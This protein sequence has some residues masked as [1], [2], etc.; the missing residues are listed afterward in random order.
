MSKQYDTP[1]RIKVSD[2]GKE[3]RRRKLQIEVDAPADRFELVDVLAR[4]KA[5]ERVEKYLH[6]GVESLISRY[7]EDGFTVLREASRKRSIDIGTQQ[8]EGE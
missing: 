7:L 1:L 6:Q 3:G 2:G 8:N 5:V 4:Y